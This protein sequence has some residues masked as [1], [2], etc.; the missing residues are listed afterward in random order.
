MVEEIT[1]IH[2]L[3]EAC[4]GDP[5]PLWA[6]QGFRK[7]GRAWSAGGAVAVAAPRACARDRIVLSGDHKGA[8]ELAALALE[9]MG[10]GF[11]P[12]GD[13]ALVRSVM[14][15]LPWLR[16]TQ[17]FGW[18]DTSEVPR[19]AASGAEWLGEVE[20]PEV[21]E[22]LTRA[23]P[24]SYARVGMD[25]VSRWAGCR[26]GGALVAV[27]ADAWSSPEVG[28]ISGVGTDPALRGQ[29]LGRKVCALVAG[30]LLETRPLVALLVDADNDPAIALY[31][32][33]G[34]TLRIVASCRVDAEGR[35][36]AR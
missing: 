27:A 7:G 20:W 23:N 17:A 19:E 5:Y 30:D 12:Q 35:P 34:F 1:D 28:F 9:E 8:A 22:L 13:L 32:R 11:R 18:M 3:A 24:D 16:F 29:G 14:R 26:A 10:T 33:L 4:H 21:A 6:A 15:Q 31:R 2:T 36:G 25:G